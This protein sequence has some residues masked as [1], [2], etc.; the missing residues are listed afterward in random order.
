MSHTAVAAVLA[1]TD[2]SMGERLVA[3][4]LASFADREERAFPGNAPGAARAGLGR[5]R[6]LEAREQLV[7]NGL[8]TIESAGRGRGRATTLI[9]LFAK[10]GP[11]RDGEINARLLEQV[12][13]RSLLR[14]PARLLLATLAALANESGVVDGLSTDSSAMPPVWPTARIAGRGVL[15]SP[16]ARSS[17]SMTAAGVVA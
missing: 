16:L 17:S 6:Y 11:W 8:V 14:G 15:C 13:S 10:S 12:L 1:R 9:V 2:L 3:L 4:S 7:S 5:S